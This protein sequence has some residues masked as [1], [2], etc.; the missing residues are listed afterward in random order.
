MHSPFHGIVADTDHATCLP[1]SVFLN[2][3]SVHYTCLGASM[4]L[5]YQVFETTHYCALYKGAII[6][7]WAHSQ[8]LLANVLVT[9][10]H[11]SMGNPA[12]APLVE[13]FENLSIENFLYTAVSDPSCALWYNVLSNS[14]QS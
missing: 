13:T 1:I 2:I 11:S 6:M 12:G 7:H 4:L 8:A 9:G 5:Y 14:K 10:T 3:V